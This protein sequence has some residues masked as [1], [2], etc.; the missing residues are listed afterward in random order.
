MMRRREFITLLGGAA[1]AW[2]LAAL[3]QQAAMPVIG[4]PEKHIDRTLHPFGCGV[5]PGVKRGRICRWPER[6]DR[7]SFGRRPVRSLGGIGG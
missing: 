5:S 4:F 1:A 3:A 6:L 2:P 7:L